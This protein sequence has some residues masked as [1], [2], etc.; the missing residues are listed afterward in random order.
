MKEE[1]Q[2]RGMAYHVVEGFE[3]ELHVDVV[4]FRGV[5]EPWAGEELE[6]AHQLDRREQAQALGVRAQVAQNGQEAVVQRRQLIDA[7][8]N[9]LVQHQHQEV[10]VVALIYVYLCIYM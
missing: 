10:R 5:Q 8:H 7:V 6:Q 1:C 2:K 4:A 9:Q 3:E